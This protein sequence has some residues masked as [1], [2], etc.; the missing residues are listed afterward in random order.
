MPLVNIASTSPVGIR[1][2]SVPLPGRDPDMVFNIAGNR[3]IDALNG[4]GLTYDVDQTVFN[5]WLTRHPEH[6]PI[7]RTI[8]TAEIDALATLA[9]DPRLYGYEQRM[10]API[11]RD[12]PYARQQGSTLSC[13]MGNWI[14][15]P[16]SYHYQWTV[17]GIQVGTGAPDCPVQPGDVGATATCTVTAT[18]PYG[19]TTAPPS[20]SVTIT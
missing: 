8:T 13:T 17:D 12:V 19:S 14:G 18:N 20:N 16:D 9:T 5:D 1:I 7:L 15:E 2:A 4:V 3:A 10:Q 6:A 11:V